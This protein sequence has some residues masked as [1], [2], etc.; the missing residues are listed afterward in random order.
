MRIATLI[1]T[2]VLGAGVLSAQ[3][4]GDAARQERIRRAGLE[5]HSQLLTNEDLSREKI[6][7]ATA[8]ES[9]VRAPQAVPPQA[10]NAVPAP[11]APVAHRPVRAATP[12]ARPQ[13]ETETQEVSL[14]EY[15]REVRAARARRAAR[16]QEEQTVSA[17]P[18]APSVAAPAAPE[19]RP[20][21]KDDSPVP[22]WT[23]HE[24]P[25]FSLG[26]YARAQRALRRKD[27]PIQLT[28]DA[29]ATPAPAAAPPRS[30]TAQQVR[31]NSPAPAPAAPAA[32]PV[33][34]LRVQKGDSLWKLS[35][36]H[37]GEG[38]LWPAIWAANPQVRNPHRIRPG[39]ALSRPSEM[40][41]AKARQGD[42]G[43]VAMAKLA[44]APQPKA[45]RTRTVGFEPGSGPSLRAN[46]SPVAAP[47]G[48]VRPA[49]RA[50]VSSDGK[51]I[52]ARAGNASQ[53]GDAARPVFPH[54]PGS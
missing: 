39:Q 47:A 20:W 18:S 7:P 49:R 53:R 52:R 4:L 23:A 15:A 34:A 44:S 6:L 26:E 9:A 13:W 19:Q 28:L 27:V 1:A 21:A 42:S 38:R 46:P 31:K 3:S 24:Q 36:A 32:I 17:N 37:L 25:G 29:K 43:M 30:L 33:A 50:A 22:A 2:V 41:V 5:K 40:Q 14:G 11:A 12:Q 54:A 45:S 16:A 8:S 51:P 48:L 35:R 10:A